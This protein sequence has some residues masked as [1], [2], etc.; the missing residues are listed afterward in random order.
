ML[1][2]HGPFR[3]RRT[4]RKVPTAIPE[5]VPILLIGLGLL[6]LGMYRRKKLKPVGLTRP[7]VSH[8]LHRTLGMEDS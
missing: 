6:A 3:F 7:S 1:L 2:K 5:P 8:E 4:R